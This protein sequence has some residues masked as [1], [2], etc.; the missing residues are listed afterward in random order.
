MVERDDFMRLADAWTEFVPRVYEKYP[1]LLAE[2]YA[3]SMA[4]CTI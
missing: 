1:M 2:M 4:V 3:Y